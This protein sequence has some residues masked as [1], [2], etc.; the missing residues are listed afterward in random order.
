VK[1]SVPPACRRSRSQERDF[2]PDRSGNPG[3]RGFGYRGHGALSNLRTFEKDLDT[4]FHRTGIPIWITEYGIQTKPGQPRGVSL[5]RQAAYTSQAMAS[6]V[7]DPR[8]K[9]FVWFVFRDGPTSPWHSGLLNRNNT[10]KPALT[11]HDARETERLS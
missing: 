4:W 3:K 9:M 5:A 10:P 8:V 1:L 7:N 6:A 11:L 2:Q